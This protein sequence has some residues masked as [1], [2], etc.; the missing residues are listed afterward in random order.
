MFNIITINPLGSDQISHKP[1]I[2]N[3]N[4]DK[5]IINIQK[6]NSDRSL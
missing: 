4:S 3:R 1:L 5:P 6:I 2:E